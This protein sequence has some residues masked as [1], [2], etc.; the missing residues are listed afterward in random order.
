MRRRW[1]AA[2]V[3]VMV[4]S[5]L[6]GLH[7]QATTIRAVS[8]ALRI[9]APAFAFINGPVLDRLR[10][11]RALRIDLRL[12]VRAEP[13][14]PAVVERR[15]SFNVSFDLWEERVAVTRI[16]S[17]S[18]SVSHLTPQAAEAWCL[19]QLTVA[20]TEL[21]RVGTESPMWLR[22]EYRVDPVVAEVEDTGFTLRRL[23]DTFS[24]RQDGELRRV[25]DA[26]PLRLAP[27][28]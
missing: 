5:A 28:P 13:R 26:G 12:E 16:G 24:R 6:V 19:D 27:R 2:L 8:G 23:I 11:G 22:L 7:G 20:L 17:P 4:A 3:T 18:R 10:D 25:F 15:Q 1:R 14:G 21:G 9:Q